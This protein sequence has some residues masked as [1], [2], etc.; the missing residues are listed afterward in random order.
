MVVL[1]RGW[2]RWLTGIILGSLV[3]ALLGGCGKSDN[4]RFPNLPADH[5]KNKPVIW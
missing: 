2:I 1:S 4:R 3:M 5:P